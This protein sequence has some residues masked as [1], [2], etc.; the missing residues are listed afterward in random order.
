[1]DGFYSTQTAVAAGS[2]LLADLYAV[3]AAD[4]IDAVADAIA[5][6]LKK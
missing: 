1:M 3:S 5:K 4:G 6:A 2:L